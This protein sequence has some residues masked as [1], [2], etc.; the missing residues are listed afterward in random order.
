MAPPCRVVTVLSTE[1]DRTTYLA[2]DVD[3]RRL[4]TL[5]VVRLPQDGRDEAVRQCRAR[6]R[7]LMRWSHPG[8]PRVVGGQRQPVRRLLRRVALRER[9]APRPLLRRPTGGRGVCARA[10]SPSSARSSRAVTGAASVTAGCGRT[11]VIVSGSSR[12]SRAPVVLGYSVT[13]GRTP[14]ADD[15]DRRPRGG[16]AR[17]QNRHVS[18]A[19]IRVCAPSS[20]RT[21]SPVIMMDVVRVV[22]MTLENDEP[23]RRRL[24]FDDEAG[25]AREPVDGQRGA[26]VAGQVDARAERPSD[27]DVPRV[28]PAARA[29]VDPRVREGHVD[30]RP[31]DVRGV[32]RRSVNRPEAWSSR[33]FRSCP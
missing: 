21:R 22:L 27:R 11:C 24:R 33:L 29:A 31:E 17:A 10:C 26:V 4:V 6:L 12:R 8:V 25:R 23:S 19:R 13:P 7:S 3:T 5:D 14:A 15:D 32:Q 1:D 16:R 18:P 9:A 30:A 20:K 2:E 28:V